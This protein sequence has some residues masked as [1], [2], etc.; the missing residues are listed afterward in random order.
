[1][2]NDKNIA[3]LI[4]ACDRY[5][6]LFKGFNYFFD[7]N[8]DNSISLKKYFVTEEKDFYTQGYINIKSGIGEW[9]NRLKKVLNQ[10]V[11][12]YVI[13]LQEDMWFNREVPQGV[14]PQI[15]DYIQNNELQLVKLH[16]SEVYKTKGLDIS[17]S[18]FMLS[19]VIK[20]ESDF[21]MSHQVSVW[22]KDFLYA[23]LKD[24]EHPWRNERKG[25]KR[26]KKSKHR[27]FQIDLLS[28]NGKNPINHNAN[29]IEP[30]QYQTISVNACIHSKAKTFIS[31]LQ[32]DYPEYAEKLN[33]NLENKL[34]HDGKNKPREEDFFKKMITKLRLLITNKRH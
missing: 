30:G 33:Y 32:Q 3:I 19:E 18:G 7:K 11:E 2:M 23:Q 31:E 28:E 6:L 4:F 12:D 29:G 21:L 10:I 26:L 27:I 17:F 14:L 25:T 24:N 22:K 8:W 5:E 34:T 20:E 9:S 13:F 16:S 1:M 15:L